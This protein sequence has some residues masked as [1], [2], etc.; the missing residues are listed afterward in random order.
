MSKRR[1]FMAYKQHLLVKTALTS[2][3]TLISMSRPKKVSKGWIEQ[4]KKVANQMT[5]RR[6][7]MMNK[8]IILGGV[9]GGLVG[10]A[11][12]LLLAPKPG[13][14]LI[15]DVYKPIAPAIRNLFSQTVKKT[16][17]GA[18]QVSSH[19][20][21]KVEEHPVRKVVGKG[22]SKVKKEGM[23]I[24]KKAASIKRT[25]AK[26]AHGIAPSHSHPRIHEAT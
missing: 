12:A 19:S 26:K 3:F 6:K 24:A 17:K 15:K 9:A 22:G 23:V 25:V 18:K 13:S 7:G 8:N 14:Q 5:I 20:K 10:V 16:R 2:L 4:A 11:T 21:V 1:Y